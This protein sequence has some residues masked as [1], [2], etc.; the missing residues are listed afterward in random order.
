MEINANTKIATLLKLHPNALEAIISISYKFEKLRNPLLRKIMASRTTIAMA[1]KIA[2]CHI[3]DFYNKLKP[4][5]F[6][7][8]DTFKQKEN[9]VNTEHDVL[10]KETIDNCQIF[11]LDVRPI[12]ESGNDPFALI[13]EKLNQLKL[14]QVL[15][16]INSFEPL[17]LIDLLSKKGFKIRS[18]TIN[19]NL[20]NTYFLK[21]SLIDSTV[22]DI[23]TNVDSWQSAIKKFEGNLKTIDVSALEMPLPMITIIEALDKMDTKTA[24]LV[25]HKR[26]PVF[27]LPELDERGFTYIINE[28]NDTK[29]NLLI[30][31]E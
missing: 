23:K 25:Y 11:E 28:I 27:L 10:L 16:I 21:T 30:Y 12:I 6:T 9:N 14:Q 31:K 24:L 15:K 17:P 18:E 4:L 29:V 26:I 8:D 5:G 20:V 2:N 22:G 1:S 3:D 7:F 13:Q 19:Q